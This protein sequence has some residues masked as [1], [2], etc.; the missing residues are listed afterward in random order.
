MRLGDEDLAAVRDAALALTLSDRWIL[1]RLAY[2]IKDTTRNLKTY[3]FN[4]AANTVYHFVWN[5]YC[6]WYLEMA[7]SRWTE[8]ADAEDRRAARWVAWRVLDAI[9]RLLHP[10]MP[11]V[12]EEIW[13]ALPHEGDL[14]ATSAWPRAKRAWFDADTERQV[15]FLQ[16]LVVAV[17]NLR[18]ENGLPPGR[19]VPVVLRGSAEQLDMIERLADQLRPL[20]KIEQLTL[21]RDGVRPA[22]AASA[23]VRGAEVFLPLE[24]LVDLNEERARLAREADKLL[25]DLENSRKKLRNQDFLAK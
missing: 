13:Q 4:E 8:E 24:G 10:F 7:K 9:L 5:E 2:A 12:T 21:A 20:A 6:D 17:R 3:R 22:V 18:A 11:Y 25:R 1:S 15:G 16:E 14:L 23:V 19:K